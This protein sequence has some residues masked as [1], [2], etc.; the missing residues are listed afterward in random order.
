MRGTSWKNGSTAKVLET[1]WRQLG[2]S[3]RVLNILVAE[4][5]LQSGRIVPGIG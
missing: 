2:V 3:H 4:V 1:I 5:S